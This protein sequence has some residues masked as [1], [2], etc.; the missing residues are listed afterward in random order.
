MTAILPKGTVITCP[1]KRHRI[2][3]AN[4]DIQSGMI[5]IN[6]FDFEEGQER[7]A[8]EPTKCR[9]CKSEYI[10]QGVAH[11][12]EGWKPHDPQLEPVPR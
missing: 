2:A 11:T 8:G 1:R 10:T 5:R 3:V 7:I 12:T 4:R 6:D 9:I